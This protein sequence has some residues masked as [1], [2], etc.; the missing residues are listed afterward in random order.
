MNSGRIWSVEGI[1]VEMG[2][3][4]LGNVVFSLV[5]W[6]SEM[7]YLAYILVIHYIYMYICI[8]ILIMSLINIFIGMCIIVKGVL[9]QYFGLVSCDV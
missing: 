9:Y 3:L 4:S 6:S 2:M 1:F 7:E 8:Y 5:F